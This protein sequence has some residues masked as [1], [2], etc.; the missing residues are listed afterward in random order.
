MQN[1]KYDVVTLGE[2]LIDFTN[3]GFSNQGNIMFEANPGGAV[4]N[5]VSML[6]KLGRK[7]A[8]IAKVGEDALGHVLYNAVKEVGVDPS[9]IKF[10]KNYPTTLAFVHTGEGGERSFS[11]YRNPGA[12]IML[13][14]EDLDYSMIKSTKI[15]HLGTL[16][17]TSPGNAKA[18]RAALK[19]ARESG[20]IITLDPNYRDTLW[21]SEK[22]AIDRIWESIENCDFLKISDNEIELITGEKDIDKGIEIIKKRTPA[23]LILATLGPDGSIGYYKDLRVCADPFKMPNTIET[24]GAGDTYTGCMLDAVLEY[25]LDGFDE[26]KLHRSMVYASAA[27]AIIT[28]RKGA[29]RVMPT[30]SEIEALL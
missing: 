12:D 28:T 24:T 1:K 30:P 14:E 21:N 23:K 27:A 11:F 19:A 29:L 10:D 20:A 17:L 5:A 4:A 2:L 3:N 16:S 6:A 8:F 18:H 9:G 13:T 25:G 15:F 22:E 26:E 7:T